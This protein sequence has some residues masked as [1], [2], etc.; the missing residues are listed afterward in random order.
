MS[1]SSLSRHFSFL[2]PFESLC[3]KPDYLLSTRV[4]S[5]NLS[6]PHLRTPLILRKWLQKFVV[7][8][9]HWKFS[10]HRLTRLQAY[11]N[12]CP[13]QQLLEPTVRR[14]TSVS[15]NKIKKEGVGFRITINASTKDANSPATERKS[16]SNTRTRYRNTSFMTAHPFYDP[17]SGH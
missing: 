2:S 7:N 17:G 3:H 15:L 11:I 6:I 12:M 4:T 9:S 13:V 10:L 16:T 5:S 14:S 8:L 1:C